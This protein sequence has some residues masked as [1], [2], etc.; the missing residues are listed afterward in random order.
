[1]F[2][3][4]CWVGAVALYGDEGTRLDMKKLLSDHELSF[5]VNRGSAEKPKKICFVTDNAETIRHFSFS[6]ICC[7]SLVLVRDSIG[8]HEDT[9]RYYATPK[10]DYRTGSQPT[11]QIFDG[12]MSIDERLLKMIVAMA[13][14]VGRQ[15]AP[16]RINPFQG[17]DD[18]A[19]V[20]T[21]T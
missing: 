8:R 16:S 14:Y 15:K 10:L 13:Y 2:L 18:R 11:W 12:A 3:E 19:L 17:Y 1:M 6:E 5:M 4:K 21:I 20:C 9:R 7:S